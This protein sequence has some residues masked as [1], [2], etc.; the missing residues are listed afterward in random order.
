MG[1]RRRRGA[2]VGLML[3]VCAVVGATAGAAGADGG[4]LPGFSL[5]G[6][7]VGRSKLPESVG[8][9]F[10]GIPGAKGTRIG[11][12]GHGPVW[13]GEVARPKATIDAAGNGQWLCE[14]EV[15]VGQT[16]GGG[17]CEPPGAA[18]EFGLLDVS[19]CGKGPI[20]VFRIVGLVPDG[21]TGLEVEEAGGKIG[22]TVPVIDNTVAFSIGPENIVLQGIGQPD[23][24]E[25]ERR[26]PLA[27]TARDFGGDDQGGCGSYTFAEAG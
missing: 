1:V 10:N 4:H 22:R 21:I 14:S 23:A 17:A 25:F 8:F 9:F 18:R 27:E 3:I 24:E 11:H 15:R 12:S 5:L 16:D 13:F 2:I 26:L 7:K 6:R 20:R 19:S